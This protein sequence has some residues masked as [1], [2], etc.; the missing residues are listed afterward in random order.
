VLLKKIAPIQ[1]LAD[2]ERLL[3][4]P[5]YQRVT[6]TCPISGDLVK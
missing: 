3:Y 5:H 1:A 2:S 6:K 4:P